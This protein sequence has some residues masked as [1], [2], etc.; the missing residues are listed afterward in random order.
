MEE[1]GKWRSGG[2]EKRRRGR[3]EGEVEERRSRG[4]GGRRRG[5]GEVEE[6]RAPAGFKFRILTSPNNSNYFKSLIFFQIFFPPN[7][8]STVTFILFGF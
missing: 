8:K 5:E 2:E 4:G 1:R 6:R 3:G 7:F